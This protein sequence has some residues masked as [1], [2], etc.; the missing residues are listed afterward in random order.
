MKCKMYL[1]NWL[2]NQGGS[3][4]AP[5]PTPSGLK[6]IN[7]M[8]MSY[9]TTTPQ[10]VDTSGMTNMSRF[11]AYYGDS[12]TETMSYP[13]IDTSSVTDMSLMF[14]QEKNLGLY[15]NNDFITNFDTS[16]VTDM[17][18]MFAYAKSSTET[19]MTTITSFIESFDT[20][21]LTNTQRMFDH[22]TS[23]SPAKPEVPHFDTSNVTDM[24]YMFYQSSFARMTNNFYYDTSSCI[25][26]RDIFNGVSL[27]NSAGAE[28]L[29][30]VLNMCIHVNVNYEGTKTLYAL[31][32][33]SNTVTANNI[34]QCSNY[35]DFLDAGW[36]IG[37]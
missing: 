14:Q 5:T 31:G 15:L 20:S 7:G 9:W 25:N 28:T 24:Q 27:H 19:T 8:K 16:N 13:V 29:V 33:R 3:S 37:Y 1:L 22:F 6:F 36:T 30:N 12:A 10:T 17:S 34:Q 26:M 11:F 35:Q 21:K 23:T 4:P 18:Y 2:R 32:L